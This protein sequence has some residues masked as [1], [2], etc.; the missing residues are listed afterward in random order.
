MTMVASWLW[1][2]SSSMRALQLC[3]L[4][5]SQPEHLA[6][7]SAAMGHTLAA[8]LGHAKALTARAAAAN[9]SFPTM[10]GC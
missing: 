5:A 9:P 8:H 6:A 7:K 1:G 4:D 2:C 3:H 10:P